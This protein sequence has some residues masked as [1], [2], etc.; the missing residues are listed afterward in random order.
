MVT[1]CSVFSFTG[2]KNPAKDV[3]AAAVE[4]AKSDV[5]KKAEMMAAK[6]AETTTYQPQSIKVTG[7]NTQIGFVGSKVTGTHSGGFKTLSGEV[8]LASKLSETKASITIDMKSTFSDD[9]KLTGH[10][11]S[12][13][14][15]DVEKFPTSTFTINKITDANS[16]AGTHN[17]TGELM[18]HGVKKPVSFPAMV[19]DT[20]ASL[21]V[22][23][24]FSINRKDFG[25]EYPGMKDDLIRD[26]VVIR[27]NLNLPKK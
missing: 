19:T 6:E 8:A 20:A 25:I 21:E 17:I 15:F 5:G 16:E 10:L 11:M 13:D 9:P 7:E 26:E 1:A 4:D 3:P 24:E 23:T 18:F 2:C 22:N 12:P 14:F 27:L